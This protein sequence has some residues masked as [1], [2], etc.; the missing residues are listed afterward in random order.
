MYK[1]CKRQGFA[2]IY[3]LSHDVSD[4]E[5]SLSS[6]NMKKSKFMLRITA[7]LHGLPRREYNQG[8]IRDA[9][10]ESSIKYRV[11]YNGVIT[12]LILIS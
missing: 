3:E 1:G 2:W 5:L 9:L 7:A 4:D 10:I 6:K 12:K 8:Y 11:M